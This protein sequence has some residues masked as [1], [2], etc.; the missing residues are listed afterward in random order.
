MSFSKKWKMALP[1]DPVTPPLGIDPKEFKAG[2]WGGICTPMFT[3]ELFS[4]GK[5]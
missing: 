2:S 4:V 5:R 3:A 1:Y